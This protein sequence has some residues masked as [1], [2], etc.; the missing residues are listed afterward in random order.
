MTMIDIQGV[1]IF[2]HIH[3]LCSLSPEITE[4]DILPN[5]GVVTGS[6]L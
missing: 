4:R 2:T 6:K 1:K 3:S 5:E